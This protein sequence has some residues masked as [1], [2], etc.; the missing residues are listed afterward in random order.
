MASNTQGDP[1]ILAFI[2]TEIVLASIFLSWVSGVMI[3]QTGS[4]IGVDATPG[5]YN[6]RQTQDMSFDFSIT[7]LSNAS[8]GAGGDFNLYGTWVE[9]LTYSGW[10]A[11]GKDARLYLNNLHVNGYGNYDNTY[12]IANTQNSNFD[13]FISYPPGIVAFGSGG[14]GNKKI[15]LQ[16]RGSTFT[17][18][19]AVVGGVPNWIPIIGDFINNDVVAT[20]SYNKNDFTIRTTYNETS[21]KTDVY[22]DGV[23]I[24]SGTGF[25]TGFVYVGERVFGGLEVYGP[26]LV[27]KNWVTSATSVTQS[28]YGDPITGFLLGAWNFFK[29]LFGILVWDF[30]Y[31][32][33][34]QFAMNVI[35]LMFVR[36]PAY[37][38]LFIGIRLLR[39]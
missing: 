14:I 29:T 17:V 15:I 7:N 21:T 32:E 5:L 10:E 13:V 23:R 3:D 36:I 24:I 28:W 39:G 16:V 18:P 26:G 30:S 37:I 22:V 6:P 34:W 8:A 19:T 1:Q 4:G 27:L 25:G 20:K 33:D 35:Q 11:T 12:H 31:P 9:N 38:A 2:I